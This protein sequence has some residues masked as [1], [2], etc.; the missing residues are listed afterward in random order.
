MLDLEQFADT[1]ELFD[2]HYRLL[3]P[4]STDG[5]T[6]DIWLAV[7]TNTVDYELSDNNGDVDEEQGLKVAI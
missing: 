1:E 3:Y 6:A 2:G 7:D 4:L 5:A